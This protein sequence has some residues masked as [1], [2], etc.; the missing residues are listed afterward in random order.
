MDE[1][2]VD[3]DLLTVF[4]HVPHKGLARIAATLEVLGFPMVLG[5]WRSKGDH[6]F[7]RVEYTDARS[8]YT[9]AM[10]VSRQ[11]FLG[12]V[13][14]ISVHAIDEDHEQTAIVLLLY[15]EAERSWLRSWSRGIH[16]DPSIDKLIAEWFPKKE[17]DILIA[18]DGLVNATIQYMVNIF[19]G[20]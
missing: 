17:S 16:A 13:S 2:I 4:Q 18:E 8:P 7:P 14:W 9:L 19:H 20:N 10:G 12:H 6:H 1:D 3:I 11:P 5:R 15:R